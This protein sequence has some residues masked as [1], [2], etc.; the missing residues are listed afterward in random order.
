M[1]R[2]AVRDSCLTV[3]AL[4]PENHAVV[5]ILP[6]VSLT[7]DGRAIHDQAS[8]VSH[9]TVRES[10]TAFSRAEDAVQKQELDPPCNSTRKAT[11][12]TA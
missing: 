5:Q 2:H 3:L 8:V 10:L 7:V 6:E 4:S 1:D 9:S 12:I 11:T